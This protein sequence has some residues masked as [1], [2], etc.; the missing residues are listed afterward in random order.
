[1]TDRFDVP[2]VW[3]PFG[4][5]SLVAAQG[6]GQVVHLKGQVALDIAGAVVGAGDMAL[7]VE[8]TLRNV[9]AVLAAMGGRMADIY[10]LTHYAT[11][12]EAFMA[13]GEIRKR[14]FP[15][16]YPITT[17][18]EVSRLFHPDLLIEITASAEIPHERYGR[19]A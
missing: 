18:I 7:Q 9:D 16:P 11:D 12:I 1:M 10:S 14:F 15:P 19:P 13:C 2:G 4:A 8:Q 17:T 5:F 3:Q 6:S